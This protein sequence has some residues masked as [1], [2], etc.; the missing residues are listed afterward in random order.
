MKKDKIVSGVIIEK[1][2]ITEYGK[3]EREHKQFIKKFTKIK[4]KCS[5]GEVVFKI[6]NVK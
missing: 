1:N 5:G 2:K 4:K 6:S 3:T